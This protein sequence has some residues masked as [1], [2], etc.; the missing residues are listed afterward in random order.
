M[1]GLMIFKYVSGMYDMQRDVIRER[2]AGTKSNNDYIEDEAAPWENE[3]NFVCGG[4]FYGVDS[5]T[6]MEP[7]LPKASRISRWLAAEA[8]VIALCRALS[9]ALTSA[10]SAHSQ[11]VMT[12]QPFSTKAVMQAVSLVRLASSFLVQKERRLLGIRKNLQSGC[13]CQKHPLTKTTV[14]HLVSTRSGLPGR[15]RR[16]SRKRNPAAN[17]AERTSFSGRVFLPR[18]PDIIRERTSGVTT[19]ATHFSH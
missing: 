19:S 12:F 2:L 7:G 13:A 6:S 9:T 17:R 3:G 10:R 15:S 1:L 8:S 16:C 4:A 5:I 14:R 18:M 11:T